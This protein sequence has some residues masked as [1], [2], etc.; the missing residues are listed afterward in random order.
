VNAAALLGLSGV[1]PLPGGSP[2]VDALRSAVRGE[3]DAPDL[4]DSLAPALVAVVPDAV[5]RH[6]AL[7]VPPDVTE[8][9]LADVGRKIE[10]Y[11]A[12]VDVPWLVGLMRAD[13]LA[14]GRL[15]FERETSGGG[16]AIH[17]PEGGGLRPDLVDA[18]LAE[19]R[20]VFGDGTLICTSW[21]LDP[22]LLQ[23]PATS[24]IVAFARRFDVEPTEPGHEGDQA[25]AKF[26][27]R[28]S[29]AEVLDPASVAPR[30]TLEH[31]VAGHLRAGRHWS[32]P[33]GTLRGP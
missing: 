11:G 15:Q 6:R 29:L 16:R 8:A 14:L 2:S 27:F 23:L 10:A 26:V 7:G 19:A 22:T 32:E 25:A 30:T 5:E 18:S 3:S 28:R 17:I 33:R 21:L 12:T 24:N 4:V 31:L 20:A 1:E 13:V 9:T